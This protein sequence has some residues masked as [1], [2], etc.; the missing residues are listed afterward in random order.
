MPASTRAP[1]RNSGHAEASR[2]TISE[3]EPGPHRHQDALGAGRRSFDGPGGCPLEDP[4]APRPTTGCRSRASESHV[5]CTA[6]RGELQGAPRSPRSPWARPAADPP[7]DVGAGQPLVGEEAVDVPA[8]VAPRPPSAPRRR[9]RS[10]ARCGRRRS[11]WSARS[12]GRA[13]CGSRARRG[14][15]AGRRRAARDDRGGAVAEQAAR[16]Q[17]RHRHVVALDG[18]RAQLDATRTADLVGWPTR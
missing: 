11:P 9:A 13:G 10:A 8:H 16:D 6:E 12:R 17:V 15:A 2:S 18:Q 4:G 5:S 3:A 14:P 1:T 7:A